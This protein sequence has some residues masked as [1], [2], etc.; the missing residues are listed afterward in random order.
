MGRQED[1]VLVGLAR[2]FITGLV[3]VDRKR[4]PI[5]SV[6]PYSTSDLITVKAL[7]VGRAMSSLS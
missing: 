5:T 1:G 7:N 2:V 6:A 4:L 3:I